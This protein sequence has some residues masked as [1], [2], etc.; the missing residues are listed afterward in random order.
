[1]SKKAGVDARNNQ[2]HVSGLLFPQMKASRGAEHLHRLNSEVERFKANDPFI[3]SKRDDPG[4]AL[5]IYRLE[6]R[7]APSSIAPTPP[8]IRT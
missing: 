3:V 8:R 7:P 4:S 2:F 6:L 5:H 1:M